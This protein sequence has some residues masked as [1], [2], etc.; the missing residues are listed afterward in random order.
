MEVKSNLVLSRL[1]GAVREHDCSLQLCIASQCSTT[2]AVQYHQCG[3]V[4]LYAIRLREVMKQQRYVQHDKYETL[5]NLLYSNHAFE[6]GRDAGGSLCSST[7]A[8]MQKQHI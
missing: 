7:T 1:A 6:G 4:M 5:D 8:H 2:S 3:T